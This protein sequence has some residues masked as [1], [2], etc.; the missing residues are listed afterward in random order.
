[1]FQKETDRLLKGFL[2]DNP[3]V[4]KKYVEG[5]VVA[6]GAVLRPIN[7]F[8]RHLLV[9]QGLDPEAVPGEKQRLLV[10]QS[11][12]NFFDSKHE[13][14]FDDD[15]D[16]SWVN[17]KFEK[18]RGALKDLKMTKDKFM[19]LTDLSRL[20]NVRTS[21]VP[22]V[23]RLEDLTGEP[24]DH[25]A[26][27][28][29]PVAP[30][31]EKREARLTFSERAE[32][33]KRIAQDI[34]S[35]S[36][37]FNPGDAIQQLRSFMNDLGKQLEDVKPEVEEK[38]APLKPGKKKLNKGKRVGSGL[39]VQRVSNTEPVKEV[40]ST[41]TVESDRKVRPPAIREPGRNLRDLASQK[42]AEIKAAKEATPEFKA[43][44]ARK[45]ARATE[46]THLMAQKGL[47]E[48]SDTAFNTQVDSM[49][50]W[51]D[52]NFDALER[53]VTK[54]G[55]TKDAVAENKFKGSFRRAKNKV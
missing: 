45:L 50:N 37:D 26:Q 32:K 19:E 1:M 8:M 29:N 10:L 14:D 24:I 25:L 55:P 28:V 11:L 2:N 13:K 36:K 18:T 47:V 22:T 27:R 12:T 46:L 38:S 54:Y 17:Q 6:V 15:Y 43:E 41:L 42:K 44:A 3:D 52:N 48:A 20:P 5:G 23:E 35:E 33:L 53:V 51:S 39:R 34:R 30:E 49:K 7:S 40:P 31:P 4:L 9:V 16:L 21:T